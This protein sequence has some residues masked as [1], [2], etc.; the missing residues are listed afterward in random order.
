MFSLAF[1]RAAVWWAS[2]SISVVRQWCTPMADV[3]IQHWPFAMTWQAWK[4]REDWSF[5]LDS[6]FKIQSEDF[7]WLFHFCNKTHVW[8]EREGCMMTIPFSFNGI[9]LL[10]DQRAC[11]L[12]H[13]W[14]Q[15]SC[16]LIRIDLTVSLGSHTYDFYFLLKKEDLK[17]QNN[18]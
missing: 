6:N 15:V 17:Q 7:F 14:G 2:S 11:F 4:W 16:S 12:L 13:Y 9:W 10:K 8:K 18:T 3:F 1:P 5:T